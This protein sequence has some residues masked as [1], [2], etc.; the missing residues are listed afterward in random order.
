[1]PLFKALLVASVVQCAQ[2]FRRIR[3]HQSAFEDRTAKV[4]ALVQPVLEK[5]GE[6]FNVGISFGFVNSDGSLGLA[7]GPNGKDG[8]AKLAPKTRVPVGSAT[9]PWTA[10]LMMQMAEKGKLSLNDLASTWIDPILEK[11]YDTSLVKMWGE[12]A[13]RVTVKNLLG[14]T[15]GFADYED[16]PMMQKT[17]RLGGSA[18]VDPIEYLQ[19]A[20]QNGWVCDPNSCA[21]YSGANYILLGLA[22]VTLQGGE[23]WEDLDQLAVIPE[24]AMAE[25]KYSH[26][27]FAKHGPCTDYPDVSHQYA[28]EYTDM[29]AK[30]CLNGWTMGNILTTGEDMAQFFYDLFALAPTGQGLV[31]ATTLKAMTKVWSPM[32]HD[33]WCE[34]PEGQGSCQYALGLQRHHEALDV[35]PVAAGETYEDV[36]L[37][38]HNGQNWGSGARACGYNPEL[39]FGTCIAYTSVSGM[40]PHLGSE[41]NDDA[42]DEASCHIYNAVLE[43]IVGSPRLECPS[44]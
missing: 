18:D 15:A 2:G 24:A 43:A 30:S 13:A 8:E 21:A 31:N 5:M 3:P 22:L 39:L 1:M 27:S 28:D 12:K 9:K 40:S 6:K 17:L 11:Q 4:A 35:W 23:K 20:A 19:S 25:G 33:D 16:D 36:K 10:V 37:V 41:A 29:Q 14:M 38:G 7:G 34:G 44:A 32:P 42:L 26:T